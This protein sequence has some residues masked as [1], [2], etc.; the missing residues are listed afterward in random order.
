MGVHRTRSALG[1]EEN[2]LI[3]SYGFKPL[4]LALYPLIILMRIFAQ[5][6][7]LWQAKRINRSN[8][9]SSG[10]KLGQ[11]LGFPLA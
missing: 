10:G 3:I 7:C 4:E 11:N 9:P 1:A 8:S 2:Y 6:E 5:D